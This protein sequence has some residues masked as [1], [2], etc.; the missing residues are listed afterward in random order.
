MGTNDRDG[1]YILVVA[2]QREGKL[3]RVSLET[4]AG[5]QA[6]AAET[7]WTLEAA[8]VG[9]GAGTSPPR[10]RPGNVTK[11]LRHR[12]RQAGALTLP[13]ALSRRSRVHRP[14]A[15]QA[16]ADAAHLPGT[17]LRAEAGGRAGSLADQRRGR[18]QVRG[19]Q[20]AVHA[21]DVPGEICRRRVVRR[22]RA[23]V[24]YLPDGRLRGDQ[25][26]MG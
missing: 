6:L 9:S 5:A 26:E 17:R 2:E 18:L 14:E 1:R 11:G 19:R 12:V 4:L 8:V 21:A 24:R 15:A 10:S 22:A 13:T 20:A 7:G 16:G 23:V 3:N 25:V